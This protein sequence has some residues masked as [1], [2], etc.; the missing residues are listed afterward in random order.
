[1]WNED[2][3]MRSNLNPQSALHI[4]PQLLY[5]PVNEQFGAKSVRSTWEEQSKRQPGQN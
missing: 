4:P 1:M 2:C 3:G 5:I